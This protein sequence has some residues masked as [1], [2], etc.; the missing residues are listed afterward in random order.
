M[1]QPTPLALLVTGTEGIELFPMLDNVGIEKICVET[2]VGSEGWWSG[3]EELPT[4]IDFPMNCGGSW[5]VGSEGI[6]SIIVFD[7][8]DNVFGNVVVVHVVDADVQKE[9]VADGEG[10]ECAIDV[11][12]PHGVT[13]V[14][15][16]ELVVG[17]VVVIVIFR[18]SSD[19]VVAL[20]S[21]W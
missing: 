9:D 17:G 2:V 12:I 20:A 16:D 11:D 7:V 19:A 13:A 5:T 10:E 8:W 21:T 6:G 4:V 14:D 15:N 1:R 3:R 18:S